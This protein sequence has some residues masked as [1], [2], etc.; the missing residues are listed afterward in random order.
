MQKSG[1][2]NLEVAELVT[3]I[4]QVAIGQP[5]WLQSRFVTLAASNAESLQEAPQI[6]VPNNPSPLAVLRRNLRRSG[7]RRIEAALAEVTTQLQNLDLSL[8]DRAVLAGR[9]RELRTAR[10]LVGRLLATPALPL[11]PRAAEA[12]PSN[13][14]V[15]TQ[16]ALESRIQIVQTQQMR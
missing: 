16:P 14:F 1:G 15:S 10:W 7:I 2:K 13:R 5:Y 9:Q 11:E 3:V 6:E 12:E 4:R 8:V